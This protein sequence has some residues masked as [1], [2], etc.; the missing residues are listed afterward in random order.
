[1]TRPPFVLEAAAGRAHRRAT[2][3][4]RGATSPGDGSRP[5]PPGVLSR[6]FLPL[7]VCGVIA[8]ASCSSPFPRLDPV[9]PVEH[10]PDSADG[11]KRAV[12]ADRQAERETGVVAAAHSTTVVPRGSA[13]R[14]DRS[15]RSPS[16]E[17]EEPATP[18]IAVSPEQ[19]DGAKSLLSVV[20][21]ES[22]PVG[23]ATE[24]TL[25]EILDHA[26]SAHP[27]L[28]ARRHEVSIARAKL[29][30]AGL[31][32]NPRLV[33]DT[34]SPVHEAG[35]TELTTRV[36]FE[37]PTGGKRRL[38][39]AVAESEIQRARAAL[40]RETELV[41]LEAA[42][43]AI[44]TLYW[45]ELLRLTTRAK[46]IAAEKAKLTKPSR[47]NRG[48]GLRLVDAVEAECD[49][50]DAEARWIDT[51]S[52]SVAAQLR[53]SKAV[54]IYPPL[55]IQIAGTVEVDS[56]PL[57]SLDEVIT[58]A[59]SNRPELSEARA[60]LCTSQRRYDLSYAERVPNVRL[61]PRYR[62]RLGEADDEIG[63]R[64]NVDIPLFDRNQ[65]G[66]L[67]SGAEVRASRARF[68]V[69]RLSALGDV[70]EAFLEIESLHQA[71]AR[72]KA[73][74]LERMEHYEALLRDPNAQQGISRIQAL[75]LRR[76]LVQAR[77]TH[78][79]LRCRYLRLRARLEIVLGR[80]LHTALTATAIP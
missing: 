51:Q 45:Q 25:E 65:G 12:A 66:I 28:Q 14:D 47:D 19:P 36:T 8:V 59:R 77:I 74:G 4:L 32:P 63:V 18:A 16:L 76:R 2:H 70:A 64:F 30:T 50:A 34:D 39:K 35:P 9:R 69:A 72:Y 29:V 71:L 75:D 68:E 60:A 37:I 38:R 21:R 61:G 53:L 42:D 24:R 49:A 15:P 13:P 78:L 44:T 54:G 6:W 52:R 79:E 26:L 31:L 56:G 67:E 57:L 73:G 20:T 17:V 27:L 55:P 3:R 41:L 40:S 10:P 23:A 11:S 43:A 1:M 22:D 7:V 80:S 33:M 62:D 5:I 48:P 46:E 58:I